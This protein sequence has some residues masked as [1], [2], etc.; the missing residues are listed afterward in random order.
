MIRFQCYFGTQDYED[1]EFM[2]RNLIKENGK[3]GI[4]S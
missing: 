1:I 2:I 4:V 3:W